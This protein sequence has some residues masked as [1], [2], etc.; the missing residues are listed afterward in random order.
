MKINKSKGVWWNYEVYGDYTEPTLKDNLAYYIYCK[1]RDKNKC[2]PQ[3]TFQWNYNEFNH[4][5]MSEY[6][7]KAERII[8]LNNIKCRLNNK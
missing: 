1:G 5:L 3:V 7:I 2:V 6:F 4:S 8:K